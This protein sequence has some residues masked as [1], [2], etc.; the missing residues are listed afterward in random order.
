MDDLNTTLNPRDLLFSPGARGE[1]A[2]LSEVEFLRVCNCL[3]KGDKKQILKHVL[4]KALNA[5]CQDY[6][7]TAQ[8]I[9]K[10]HHYK[11]RH[12]M[13]TDLV[14]SQVPS[15]IEG[16]APH[17]TK[18]CL[19]QLDMHEFP[20]GLRSLT[21]LETLTVSQC[22]V[23]FVPSWISELSR[24]Q[25][26]TISKCRL[27][28]L[29][30]E[31]GT[32]VNLKKL[33][34]SLNHLHSLPALPSGIEWFSIEGENIDASSTIETFTNLRVLML[35]ETRTRSIPDCVRAT[36]VTLDWR[37]AREPITF[38]TGSP[39]PALQY[40]ALSGSTLESAV[41]LEDMPSLVTLSM[42]STKLVGQDTSRGQVTLA[43]PD[44]LRKQLTVYSYAFLG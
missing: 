12:M 38:A 31:V 26:L 10:A 40:L 39:F 21:Q 22:P 41:P 37:C 11:F 5:D 33:D 19:D 44:S 8:V 17:V 15:V 34:V 32:L 42:A 14:V 3:G 13:L 18:F 28:E 1:K 30:P 36:L 4:A 23:T 6:E 29:C 9:Q 27:V 7:A 43:I 24:L 2:Y 20:E 35:S 16:L 25:H